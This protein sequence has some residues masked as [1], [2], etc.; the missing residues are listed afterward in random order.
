MR[1]APGVV[2]IVVAGC[3]GSIGVDPGLEDLAVSGVAPATI[4][5]GTRLIVTGT[6][7]VDEAWGAATLR[8]QGTA[9]GRAVEAAWPAR[10]SARSWEA[11]ALRT[12][13]ER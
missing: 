3:A 10:S 7:F 4:V 13:K 2:A 12:S 1:S 5:P 9:G 6:S 8:L 11:R